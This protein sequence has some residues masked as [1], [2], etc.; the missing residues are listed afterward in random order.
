M[1]IDVGDIRVAQELARR[2]K[3][4][5][6]MFRPLPTQE[7]IFRSWASELL[8]R[9]GNR[10]GK[11]TVC[12]IKFAAVA[13]GLSVIFPSGEEVEQRT[14]WQK[15]RPLL[16][17]CIGLKWDHVGDTL[18]RVLFRPGLYKIIRDEVTSR[19]RAFNPYTDK[20]REL[21][22]KPSFPLIPM[23][24]VK[25]GL[26]GIAWEDKKQFQ[27]NTIEL[28]NG[29]IIKAYASTAEVKM[30]D[31]VD[32]IWIDEKIARVNHYPEW[33]ARLSD[34]KGR[35]VWSSLSDMNSAL[36]RIDKRASDQKREVAQGVRDK[37]D[38]ESYVL[39]Y[40]ANPFIDDDEKR[41][42][43]EGWDEDERK[44]RDEGEFLVGNIKVYPTFNRDV[45]C[46]VYQNADEDDELS[47]ILRKRNGEP[48][49]D[50]TRE[51]ILDPGTA[52]PGVLFGA[53][54]PRKYW[55]GN[56]PYYVI[57]NELFGLRIDADEIAKRAKTIVGEYS[58]Q[59]FIIDGMAARQTPMGFSGTIGQNYSRAFQENGL[60]CQESGAAF[61]PGDPNWSTRSQIV[62]SWLRIRT[63][64]RPLLR[65]VVDRCPN[66]VE[67]MESNLKA[68]Q[69][70]PNGETIVLDMPARG[71]K[72]D[73][74]NCLE[75]WASRA[76]KYVMPPAVTKDVGG[77]GLLA[78]Q[79][80]QKRFE[81][82]DPE[83]Q[84]VHLGP[85]PKRSVA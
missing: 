55:V 65:I 31:P 18:W 33:Q 28:K 36:L 44:L 77:P 79:F 53:I 71:Q 83:D 43:V 75:Y 80:I 27:F 56:D 74:R 16:M 34:T 59:R 15:D 58:I 76:P 12:A 20:H 19:W 62:E 26:E 9:G 68:I 67:Q 45:H 6:L 57:Y 11:S 29:T 51:L 73:V 54:P 4:G 17:W 69:N 82:T 84:V 37:A 85:G 52:K 10:S 13:R 30:G 7:S 40:S 41:K 64:G 49:G 24:E 32:Y 5:L 21:E 60:L 23:S 70:G 63:N 72:D 78:F 22:C 42:R 39:K 48:P 2:D 46:A 35:I 14:P 1:P 81:K 25:G 47:K 38:V 61:T 3:D 50:W 66:L 8:T